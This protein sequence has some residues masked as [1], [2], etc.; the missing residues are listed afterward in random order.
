MRV[1]LLAALIAASVPNRLRAQSAPDASENVMVTATRL[2]AEA[3]QVAA[4]V[5]VIDRQ[6]IEDRGYTTLVD[7]LSAVP[8]LRV[9]Q[10]GG[11]GSVASVF[12]A[13]LIRALLSP[14]R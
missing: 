11:P 10:S 7:A 5:T 9:V 2:P 4:G 13:T 8:G 12:M 3:E 14:T 1:W 6:T